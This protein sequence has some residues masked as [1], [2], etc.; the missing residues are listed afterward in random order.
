MRADGVWNIA[1][2]VLDKSFQKA[3]LLIGSRQPIHL[4][5]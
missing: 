2:K 3:L 1:N 5:K 4:A